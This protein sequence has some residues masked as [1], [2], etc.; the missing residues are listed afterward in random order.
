MHVTVCIA[1]Y[2]RAEGLRRL[3]EGIDGLTFRK[4]DPPEVRIVVVDNDPAGSASG[5][6]KGL[7]PK[8]GWPL[9]YHAEPRRGISY[10]RNTAVARAREGANFIACIDDD[11]VPEPGW[12]DELL[13]VQR[14]YAAD[15]VSGPVLPYFPD[16]VPAWV[17][18]GGF[19][20]QAFEHPRYPTGR[21]L[22]VTAT[23]NVLIRAGIFEETGLLFDERLALTGGED[24]HFFARV[25]RA[26]YKIVHADDAVVHEWIPGSRAN[27]R[28]VLRRAYRVGNAHTLIEEYLGSDKRTRAVRIA[29]GCGRIVQGVL[30]MPL[31]LPVLF[32]SG[33][34][35]FVQSLL[36]ICRGAGMLAGMIG[37]RFEEYR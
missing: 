23:S 5:V 6:C 1:T 13:H 22:E 3:L 37:V 33:R 18:R 7:A 29:K 17:V 26:G 8:L 11:E 28:W 34:W 14:S 4:A 20:E 24:V 9:D 31:S 25:R 21:E 2:R 32:L 27:A 19:F 16:P 36:Y 12:L 35:M 10:A 30:L 15:V